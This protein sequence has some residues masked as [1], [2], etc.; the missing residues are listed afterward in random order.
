M[1]LAINLP[2]S[3]YWEA[4]GEAIALTAISPFRRPR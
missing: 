3:V 2:L 1:K 4:L